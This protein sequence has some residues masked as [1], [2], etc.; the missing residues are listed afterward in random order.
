MKKFAI[1]LLESYSRLHEAPIGGGSVAAGTPVEQFIKQLENE[2]QGNSLI[3][4]PTPTDGKP[5]DVYRDGSGKLV[6]KKGPFGSRAPGIEKVMNPQLVHYSKLAKWLG[7]GDGVQAPEQR[8]GGTMS[9]AEREEM[10][11]QQRQQETVEELNQGF[12]G[13]GDAVLSLFT[14][15]FESVGVLE[16]NTREAKLHGQFFSNA[17]NSIRTMSKK[18]LDRNT[19]FVEQAANESG[20]DVK[21]FEREPP[22]EAQVK[23]AFKQYENLTTLVSQLQGGRRDPKNMLQDLRKMQQLLFRN[24]KGQVFLKIDGRSLAGICVMPSERHA[25][26]ELVNNYEKEVAKFEKAHGDLLEEGESLAIES[27]DFAK[28][29]FNYSN[30]VKE[31]SETLEIAA[32]YYARGEFDKARPILESMAKQYKDSIVKVL[33]LNQGMMSEQDAEVIAALEELGAGKGT[34]QEVQALVKKIIIGHVAP[35]AEF[36]RRFKPDFVSRVGEGDVG[37]GYKPDNLLVWSQPPTDSALNPFVQKVKF[38]DLDATT[39][40]TI[41]ANGGVAGGDYYVAGVSLKTYSGG[42]ETKTGSTYGFVGLGE[43]YGTGVRLGRHEAVIRQRMIGAGMT[44]QQFDAARTELTKL[45]DAANFCRNI[46]ADDE[47]DLI[48]KTPKQA[49]Q[50]I[51]NHL[52]LMMKTYNIKMPL[53]DPMYL[54]SLRSSDGTIDARSLSRFSTYL[55]KEMQMKIIDKSLADRGK[56]EM[57]KDDPMLHAMLLLGADA[58]LDSTQENVMGVTTKTDTKESHVYN[59]NAEI[60]KSIQG[61]MDGSLEFTFGRSGLRVAGGM[62]VE[63]NNERNRVAVNCYI[64]STEENLDLV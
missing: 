23:R 31:T 9:K 12:P 32:H 47:L 13:L 45:T 52:E 18:M 30:I 11:R 6:F 1:E 2:V 44:S 36:Y 37:K 21:V 22:S 26:S 42:T 3:T 35:R 51:T 5:L 43:R 63:L 20:D 34:K 4:Y 10:E 17:N 15:L 24:K 19:I 53:N 27:F 38:Q 54:K 62:K 33:K 58:G 59:Q 8:Q 39:Q 14:K 25:L 28:S 55:E 56:S 41:V 50:A 48:G 16:T 40:K 7:S 29:S 57:T 60:M 64:P 61:V 49:Q 46:V